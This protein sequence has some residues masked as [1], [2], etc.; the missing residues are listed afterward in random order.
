MTKKIWM[1]IALGLVLGGLSLYLNRDWFAKDTI[2]IFSRSR[3]SRAPFFR[4]KNPDNSPINPLIFTFD[5]KVKLTSLK[6]IP[7]S[8]IQTN[9]FPHPIWQ[10]VSES[11]SVPIK[12][13]SY[14]MRIQGMHP[15]VKGLEPEPLEPGIKYRLFVEANSQ[16]LEH[17]FVPEARTP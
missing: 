9:S 5:R 15:E 4:R 12:T 10:L 14:G 16:K 13:F 3:P 6:V 1:L 7:V 17:D 8:S 2:Q 11:N